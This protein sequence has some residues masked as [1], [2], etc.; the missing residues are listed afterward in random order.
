MK[1]KTK[2][3]DIYRN[4]DQEFVDSLINLFD[5]AKQDALITMTIEED[6]KF[7]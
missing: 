1:N 7:F 2:L 3:G 4:R 6:K 5:I